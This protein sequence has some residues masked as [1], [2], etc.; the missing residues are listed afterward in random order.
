MKRLLFTVVA[1]LSLV[2]PVRAQI[3]GPNQTITVVDSGTACVTA[4]AACATYA[5]DNQTTAVTIN[6]AGTW[7]GTLTFEGTNNDSTWVA[8]GLA[9]NLATGAQGSTT[10]ASGL[11]SIANG[12]VIKIRVRATAAMTG[13]ALITAAKGLGV[14]RAVTIPIGTGGAAAVA[15]GTLFSG[16]TPASNVSTTETDLI[17]YTLPGGTLAV[18]GR[19]VR[20]TAWGST[21]ANTNSKTFRLYFGA[22]AV[23]VETTAA[24]A[25]P[26][27]LRSTVLRITATTQTAG[28]EGYVAGNGGGPA[29]YA[30]A[31]TLA[32]AIVIK[33][34][35]QSA[36]AGAD[37]TAL[38]FT[39]EAM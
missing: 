4:P 35:G 19:G 37:L 11:F 31:E 34:T 30:P 1:A 33:V 13:A 2:V 36:V 29:F 25:S 8:L 26:W 7:T 15:G 38:G 21:A 20:I 24:S 14:A 27:F 3:I 5:L 9:T 16:T 32:T 28:A 39:V 12:G 17:T 23:N 22:T 10:T 18:N 6:V